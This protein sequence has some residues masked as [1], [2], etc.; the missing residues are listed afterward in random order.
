MAEP[1]GRV[2]VAAPNWLGDAVMGLPAVRAV[3]AHAPAAHL[4]VAARPSVAAL[5]AMVPEVDAVI[6]LSPPAP[7][8]RTAAWRQDAARLAAERFDLAILLPNSFIAAWTAARAAIP[9][10]WG[11]AAG[12]RG[13]LLTRG[14]S[15]PPG[16]PHQADYYLTLVAALGLPTVP[17][18]APIVV[19]AAARQAA[20]ALLDDTVGRPFVVLAPGA[21]YGRAKQW[22]PTSFATLALR[23]WRE[24]G[25]AAVIVGAGGDAVASAEL[26][27]ALRRLD[28]GRP[29]LAALV[30]L[31][32]RTDLATLAA[33]LER[34]HAVVAND[35][36]AM[37][38]A[39]ATGTPVV[40]VFGATNEHH[41]APLGAR[42]DGPPPRIASHDVW[43]RPCMLRECPLGH[44]CMHGVSAAQVFALLP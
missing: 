22:P 34:A 19:P 28:G 15:R 1:P 8:W 5:Y 4:A 12:G 21:A 26:R 31:V 17:R 35:S 44:M 24:R 10:R 18:V 6:P 29:A 32:G 39:G 42:L 11:Y 27:D 16:L 40:A 41:T 25:L 36:G 20:A 13:R 2:V 7:L 3:R 43:C 37:H 30:D 38:L 23:L 9:E 14:V 33:V